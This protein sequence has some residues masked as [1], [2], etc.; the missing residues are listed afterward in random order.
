MRMGIILSSILVFSSAI[1]A[2]IKTM[3][4]AECSMRIPQESYTI[5]EVEWIQSDG[6][7]YINT[8]VIPNGF[9]PFSMRCIL[10][11]KFVATPFLGCAMYT[12]QSSH[13]FSQGKTLI[14]GF[15]MSNLDRRFTLKARV[16]NDHMVW[17][18]TQ[19]W[20]NEY[21]DGKMHT[22]NVFHN[23]ANTWDNSGVEVDGNQMPIGYLFSGSALQENYETIALFGIMCEGEAW[24]ITDTSVGFKIQ[25]I[26]IGGLDL[27]AV[28]VGNVGCMYDRLSGE[29]FENAGEGEFIIGPDKER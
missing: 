26:Q 17:N 27:V 20:G 15:G 25:S 23:N 5:V 24:Y 11:T 12:S 21:F 10:G 19:N 14:Y 16:M 13:W 29:F 22:I 7:A 2:P 9:L 3:I 1:S 18:G 4:G 8:G 28:R 6:K